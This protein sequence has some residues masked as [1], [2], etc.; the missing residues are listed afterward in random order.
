MIHI[1][2]QLR[3]ES[4]RIEEWIK[5]H[6]RLGVSNFIIY[7]DNSIDNSKEIINKISNNY[8][9]KL[10]D[11][12]KIGRY[13][14]SDNPNEYGIIDAV[15]R[16]VDSYNKGLLYIKQ[17][18][19]END[20]IAFIEVDEFL[21]PQKKDYGLL[22]IISNINFDKIYVSSYDFKCP[23]DLN[24]SIIN[25]T[26]L[27]W[28]DNTRNFMK[29]GYFSGRGKTI[30]KI[31][32]IDSVNDIH[33]INNSIKYINDNELIKINH[34]RNNSLLPIFD[35]EDRK[36]MEWNDENIIDKPSVL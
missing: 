14:N 2:T 31:R 36:I 23:F 29:N 13:V 18:Y 6:N 9:I 33:H 17:H 12:N 16:V 28:S 8:S 19:N 21:V 35:Y 27:R 1:V 26:F 32:S 3:N 15:R 20:W 5:Y 22:D 10:F 7:D 24:K 4:K 30:V 11:S 34:Y 25:Q